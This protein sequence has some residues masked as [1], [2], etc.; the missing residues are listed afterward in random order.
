MNSTILAS[1]FLY[2]KYD[3]LTCLAHLAAKIGEIVATNT[4][5][6][7]LSDYAIS[8]AVMEAIQEQATGPNYIDTTLIYDLRKNLKE[9]INEFGD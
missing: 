6:A 5:L 3:T 8:M 7:K 2:L 4:N 1:Y 9:F